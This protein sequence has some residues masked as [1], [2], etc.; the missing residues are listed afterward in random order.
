M[1]ECANFLAGRGHETHILATQW[2]KTVLD[3]RV[4][5]HFVPA[6]TAPPLLR[7]WSFRRHSRRVLAA[8][9]EIETLGAFGV[10][11]PPGVLW[12]Q[13]VHGAWL[14]ISAARR[15]FRGRLKQ[16]LNPVHPYTIFLEKRVFGARRYRHLIAL[17]P[18]VK[19]DLMRLYDVPDRDI[20]VIPNG[21][22]PAE[23]HIENRAQRREIV[24]EQLGIAPDAQV[25]VFVAN[26]LERKGFGPL[27]RAAA[28]LA[29]PNL[30]ILAV[31]RL[32][33]AAYAAEIER[34]GFKNRV[35]FP[36]PSDDVAAFYAAS[37]VFALPTQYEAWGLVIVEAMACGLPVVTS[38]LAG[39]AVAVQ[40]QKTGY[41]LQNP[42]DESEIAR[43]LRHFLDQNAVSDAMISQSVAPYAWSQVLLDYERVLLQY[44]F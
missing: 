4:Q 17:T 22:S 2:D 40:H 20:S 25:I 21:F 32:D 27:L 26:E 28:S 14:E 44:H 30:H 29:R 37:D 3:P 5:T 38:A 18:A 15:D 36:G 24:R 42:A 35:H 39:A 13:S 6:K 34:L 33:G 12:V 43:G 16:K 23:F 19:S 11:S 8:L 1:L 10:L 31:G 7:L 41:L 9:P